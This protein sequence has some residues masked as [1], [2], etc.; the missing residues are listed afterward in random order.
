MQRVIR[1]GEV[2]AV[3]GGD[4]ERQILDAIGEAGRRVVTEVELEVD[5][6]Y[7]RA[8]AAWPMKSGTSRAS[9]SRRTVIDVSGVVRGEIRAGASYA[10]FIQSWQIGDRDQDYE[11]D[12]E[13]RERWIKKLKRR[14]V[15]DPARQRQIARQNADYVGKSNSRA[16]KSGSAMWL[17][18]RW[19]EKLAAA[20]LTEELRDVIEA[21]LAARLEG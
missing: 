3:I 5:Q 14:G 9:L 11:A 12:P 15:P 2:E 4:L 16:A 1:S 21:A 10:R 20:N 6:I 13:K 7:R 18:L 17:L 8:Y 19:P